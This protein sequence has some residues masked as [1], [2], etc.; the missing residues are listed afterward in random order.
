MISMAVRARKGKEELHQAAQQVRYEILMLIYSA[1]HLSCWQSSPPSPTG[2]AA[3]MALESFLIHFRNLRAFLCP[4]LQRCSA[5][6]V[7]A[8]DFLGKDTATDLGDSIKLGDHQER[9]NK[10]LAHLSYSRNDYIQASD[11]AWNIGGMSVVILSELQRFLTLL[12]E[13]QATWFPSVAS[14][15]GVQAVMQAE[16]DKFGGNP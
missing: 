1:N 3:N 6:D 4:S 12:P 2:Y 16:V 11:Y 15:A 10:M 14:L 5:D 7:L 8:S 13:G 9:L